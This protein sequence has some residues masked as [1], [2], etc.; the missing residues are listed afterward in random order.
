VDRLF[1]IC[2]AVSGFV[3]V[4]MGV[5]SAHV[6]K[7]RIDAELLGMFE[8]AVRYQMFHA[9]ALF[10]AAWGVTHWRHRAVTVAGVLFIIGMVLFS[11]TIYVRVL[12][13]AEWATVLAPAGGV[14]YLTGWLCLAVGAWRGNHAATG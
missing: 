6:L 8:T 3:A 5:M 2:G 10:A 12:A 14:T 4:A 9:L 11:A 1:Y 7:S 13:H